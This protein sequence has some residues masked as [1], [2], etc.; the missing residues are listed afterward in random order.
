MTDAIDPVLEA[1]LRALWEHASEAGGELSLARL[2]KRAG[3][4]MSVL[5]RVLTQLADAD[6]AVVTLEE[7][8][9][10]SVRLTEE[11]EVL[12]AELFG[13]DGGQSELILH[14]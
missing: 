13:E 10:G 6:L 14:S 5:R 11:G 7:D 12:C 3:A 2:S 8:G 9:R 1:I 4:Q